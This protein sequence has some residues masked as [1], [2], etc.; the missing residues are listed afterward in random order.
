[1]TFEKIMWNIVGIFYGI[2]VSVV[3]AGF[4]PY[5]LWLFL[6]W[7]IFPLILFILMFIPFSIHI[8]KF[9]IEVCNQ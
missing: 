4:I 7:I 5:L 9:G 2:S 6:G 3:F 1:M 8:T